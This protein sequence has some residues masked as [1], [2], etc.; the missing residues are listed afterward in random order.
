LGVGVLKEAQRQ[1]LRTGRGEEL[2]EE[3]VE[4]LV[5]VLREERLCRRQRWSKRWQKRKERPRAAPL[6]AV[7]RRQ[8]TSVRLRV[9]T[10]RR[11]KLLRRISIA[12]VA[13]RVSSIH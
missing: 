7:F 2:R 8:E 6:A 5:E 12:A 13:A 4:V 1:E 10:M 9:W 11:K 3:Q